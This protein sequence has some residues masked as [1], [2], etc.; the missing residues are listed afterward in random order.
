M[1]NIFAF[2]RQFAVEERLR[3]HLLLLFGVALLARLALLAVIPNANLSTNAIE[4]II[5]GANM[6]RAGQFPSDPEFPLWVPPLTALFVAAIQSVFGESLLPVK[7][8]QVL[9]DG[10]TVLMVFGIGRLLVPYRAALL[11]ALVVAVY[12]FGAMTTIYIGTESLF[13]FFLAAFLLVTLRSLRSESVMG[14][15]GAGVLLGLACMVRGS[16]QYFPIFFIPL[17]AWLTWRR[18]GAAA[19]FFSQSAVFVIGF[20]IVVGPWAYRNVTVL[21]AFIPTSIPGL[22]LVNGSS[23]DF[24]VIEDRRRNFPAYSQHLKE[25]GVVSSGKPTWVVKDRFYR[26]AAIEKYRLR[27]QQDPWSYPWFLVR[28]FA[29]MWYATETG[30]NHG[31]ILATNLPIYGC[32]LVGLWLLLRIRSDATFVVV[33]MLAYFIAIH[34]AVY[35]LFRFIVPVMPY[36]ILMAS[37]GLLHMVELLWSPRGRGSTSGDAVTAS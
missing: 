7:L 34:A 5:N 15:L 36:I 23:E 25:I 26:E 19:K 37:L 8:A 16:A 28:K 31:L 32:A 2:I 6:I 21:G 27:W 29:R 10:F 12:P 9:L 22:P 14:F 18:R 20:A 33:G 24:W 35:S 1:R 11:G 30:N 13:S 4:A 3:T 17:L